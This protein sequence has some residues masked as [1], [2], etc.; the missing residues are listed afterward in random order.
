[1]SPL[2]FS[3]GCGPRRRGGDVRS[4]V[5][6]A[7]ALLVVPSLCAGGEPAA[8]PWVAASIVSNGGG[9]WIEISREGDLRTREWSFCRAMRGEE[10]AVEAG[11]LSEQRRTELREAIEASRFWKMPED[12]SSPPFF[13]D[14]PSVSIEVSR[15]DRT[16]RV[17]ASGLERATSPDA[18]AFR[19]VWTILFGY[20]PRTDLNDCF[21]VKNDGFVLDEH[22]MSVTGVFSDIRWDPEREML[23][24]AEVT[25]V[26]ADCGRFQAVMQ[27]AESG[28]REEAGL[29][30]VIVADMLSAD[31]LV[32]LGVPVPRL[33]ARD[34]YHDAW[35]TLPE[36]SGY[37]ASGYGVALEDRLELR[38]DFAD[39]TSRELSLPR[40]PH[41]YDGE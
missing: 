41:G 14:E 29:S 40:V 36:G 8:E 39:G 15:A 12:L 21:D 10:D 7:L 24:G 30:R 26:T 6:G 31:T 2:S 27:F 9:R 4:I 25:I 11:H 19:G 28:E 34:S 16:H 22:L 1:M 32:P 33:L 35:F 17:R 5:W 13:V 37:A 3:R 23:V 18:L 20:F 38:L